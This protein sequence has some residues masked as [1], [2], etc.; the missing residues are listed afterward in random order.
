MCA[1]RYSIFICPVCR[2]AYGKE[3]GRKNITCARCLNSY[4]ANLAR[5]VGEFDDARELAAA[6][7]NVSAQLHGGE[8]DDTFLTGGEKPSVSGQTGSGRDGSGSSGTGAAVVPSV[9]EKPGTKGPKPR[10]EAIIAAA[11][12]A[13]SGPGPRERR[14]LTIAAELTISMGSFAEED[15][16]EACEEG[17]LGG[18]P[19]AMLARFMVAGELREASAGRYVAIL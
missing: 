18:D 11:K 3:T 5:K 13:A 16:R 2:E 8:G 7:A 9:P 10:N 19:A 14:A 12:A 4:P 1:A 6:V 17:R 15:F